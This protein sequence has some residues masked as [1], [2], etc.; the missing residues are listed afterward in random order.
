MLKGQVSVVSKTPNPMVWDSGPTG[1][2]KHFLQW[3]II[4]SALG[5]KRQDAALSMGMFKIIAVSWFFYAMA[6]RA[7]SAYTARIQ[8]VH[9]AYTARTQRVQSNAGD[10]GRCPL[11]SVCPILSLITIM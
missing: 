7:H 6:Q 9:S 8:R 5:C 2:G 4:A 3:L 1:S 10:W 11:K